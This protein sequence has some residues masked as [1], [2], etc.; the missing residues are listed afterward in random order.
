MRYLLDV[1]VLIALGITRH[2]FRDRVRT[3]AA[4]LVVKGT[5]ELAT[6]SIT[7]LGFLRIVSQVPAYNVTLEQAKTQ[8]SMLKDSSTYDLLFIVDENDVSRLPAWVKSAKQTTDGHLA[9]LAASNGCVL[10]TLDENIPGAFVI[11][12]SES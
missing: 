5:P 9:E 10:A 4:S 2:Q 1:N 3:W 8:L 7:E 11:P 6:C 12:K